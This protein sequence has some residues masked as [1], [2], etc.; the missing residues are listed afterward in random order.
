MFQSTP[1]RGGRPRA[2]C[3]LSQVSIHAPAWG[4]TEFIR[5]NQ[6]STICA[7]VS[8]HAPAWGATQQHALVGHHGRSF[9][10]RPRVG[11]DRGAAR[12]GPR[13]GGDPFV[14]QVSIH[15]PAWGATGAEIADR[16]VEIHGGRRRPPSFNPRPRVGGDAGGAPRVS[17]P[18]RFQSTP[19][20]GGRQWMADRALSP[21][22]GGRR[23]DTRE[24]QSTPPRG[25]RLGSWPRRSASR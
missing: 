21:P 13:V 24:F 11:G 15:A 8:I 17:K 10:P 6:R 7:D 3:R 22:R 16:R 23:M 20:R 12:P 1:P 2:R 14:V 4:A 5:T 9:N 25:G 18:A 19:P